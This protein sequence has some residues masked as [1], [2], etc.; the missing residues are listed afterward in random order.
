MLITPRITQ[1]QHLDAS[2]DR[3]TS[4]SAISAG[5]NLA[6]NSSLVMGYPSL[7]T[8]RKE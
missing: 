6:T 8:H 1:S 4:S 7:V 2:D 5:F 3:E